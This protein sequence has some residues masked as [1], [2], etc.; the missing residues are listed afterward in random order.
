[1][2][3]TALR[4]IDM[5]DYDDFSGTE[6]AMADMGIEAAVRENIFS[7]VAGI[8][9]LGNVTFEEGSEGNC[10]VSKASWPSLEMAC[11]LL[12]VEPAV[13]QESMTMK[14]T[15]TARDQVKIALKPADATNARDAL[16]KAIYSNLFDFIVICVNKAIP[17]STSSHYIGVL[18]IAGF[19]YFEENSFEQFCINYCN[20]KLQQFFNRRVLKDEQEL[21]EKEGLGL[22][23]IE[24]I[25]N[26][27]CIDLIEKKPMCILDL[28]DEESRLP[29]PSYQHFTDEVHL[30]LK[31][32]PRL[33]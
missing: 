14:I 22:K 18:D 29:K 4:D 33:D 15:A 3:R 10:S 32:H 12:G 24:F 13:L 2:G 20:E 5:D 7:I 21:Y 23:K 31:G 16:A 17:K 30:K 25:D 26:Q 11:R 27:D 1:D 19:E 28:L 8:L 6:K 9:H